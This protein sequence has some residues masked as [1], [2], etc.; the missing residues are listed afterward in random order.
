M[1]QSI[2]IVLAVKNEEKNI[3]SCLESVHWAD[4]IIIIDNESTD[5]TV[6]I[7]QQYTDQIYSCYENLLIPELQN[8]GLKKATKDWIL[9]LDADCVVPQETKE[10]IL[11]KIQDPTYSAFKL[12]FL[13]YTCGILNHYSSSLFV[14]K[15]LKN[16]CGKFSGQAAH[17]QLGIE[18][19]IGVIKNGIIHNAHPSLEVWIR[20]MNLYSSQDAKK[21]FYHKQGGV[22]DIKLKK[23]GFI[24]LF[25]EP[26]LFA[27]YIFLFKQGW[28]NFKFGLIYSVFLGYYLFMEKAKLWELYHKKQ[29]SIDVSN[30]N[31]P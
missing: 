13:T 23:V 5:N 2:S 11:Q 3:K 17:A 29:S 26:P 7:V 28:R 20:K 18:G 6:K 24:R 4:E 31:T 8:I 21:M 10:E 14:T 15:L 30:K 25:L 1:A 9:V 27:I 19:K 12:R 16:G 22:R